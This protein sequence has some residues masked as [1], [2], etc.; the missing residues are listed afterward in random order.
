MTE[1][2]MGTRQAGKIAGRHQRTIVDWIR[3]GLLPAKKLPGKRGP[4]VIMEADLRQTMKDLYTPQPYTPG[5]GVG[6]G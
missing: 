5:D 3:K 4:Y 1:D 2:P 6:Q